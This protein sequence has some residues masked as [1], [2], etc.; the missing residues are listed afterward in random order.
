[1]G[2]ERRELAMVMACR[3]WG[4]LEGRVDL[5]R[6]EWMSRDVRF[7]RE[8]H[9]RAEGRLPVRFI[10][11]RLS[12]LRL[13]RRDRLRGRLPCMNGLLSRLRY[14]RLGRDPSVGGSR[15][16]TGLTRRAKLVSAVSFA[17]PSGMGPEKP[18]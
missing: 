14:C 9:Q 4:I 18:T 1:M 17:M 3:D 15:P 13:R 6:V 8:A 11:T 2:P 16:L 12:D 7:R 5:I 10:S